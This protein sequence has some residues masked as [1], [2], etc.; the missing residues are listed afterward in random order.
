MISAHRER[1][2]ADHRESSDRVFLMAEYATGSNAE[3]LDA[4]GQ[5]REI[6]A[7]VFAQLNQ[8]VPLVMQKLPKKIVFQLIRGAFDRSSG[9]CGAPRFVTGLSKTGWS[10]LKVLRNS[11][12]TR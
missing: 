8:L 4:Y 6:Y 12:F 10:L 1:I 7:N 2:L 9:S 11:G 3:I 5:P